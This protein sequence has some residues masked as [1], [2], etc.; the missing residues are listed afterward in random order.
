MEGRRRG[1]FGGGARMLSRSPTEWKRGRIYTGRLGGG[2][3][4][5]KRGRGK[6]KWRR[7]R[8]IR[9]GRKGSRKEKRKRM[10]RE[11]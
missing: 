8:K 9:K 11:W 10:R 6:Y 1:V 7:R 5:R 4:E 2:E 3:R